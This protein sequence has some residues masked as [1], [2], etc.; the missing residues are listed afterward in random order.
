MKTKSAFDKYIRYYHDKKIRAEQSLLEGKSV[1]HLRNIHHLYDS[2][3][4]L[5]AQ[6]KELEETVEELKKK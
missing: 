3:E 2:L 1:A 4:K 5:T 6:I